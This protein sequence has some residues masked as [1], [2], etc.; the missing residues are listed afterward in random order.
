VTSAP[1][2]GSVRRVAGLNSNR[3]GPAA[4]APPT[5]PRKERCVPSRR[6]RRSDRMRADTTRGVRSRWCEGRRPRAQS[7]P[8][9][10]GCAFP[11]ART[12]GG[13]R[14]P[15]MASP[16]ARDDQNNARD[17]ADRTEVDP[18]H[19]FGHEAIESQAKCGYMTTTQRSDTGY[20]GRRPTKLHGASI[21][22]KRTCRRGRAGSQRMEHAGNRMG[23]FTA[24]RRPALAA[25]LAGSLATHYQHRHALARCKRRYRLAVVPPATE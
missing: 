24:R 19:P 16:A 17:G 12:R 18:G 22:R 1:L 9:G 11:P 13:S 5:F 7:A 3:I 14:P 6:R 23:A 8:S 20:A 25:R 21:R 2:P 4:R 10:R 15:V